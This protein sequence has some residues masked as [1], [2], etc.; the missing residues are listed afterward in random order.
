M[1]K[2]EALR[3]YRLMRCTRDCDLKVKQAAGRYARSHR[4]LALEL[5]RLGFEG[6]AMIQ[7]VDA[8]GTMLVLVTYKDGWAMIVLHPD[9][10]LVHHDWL[11][12]QGTYTYCWDPWRK[13]GK[14]K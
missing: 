3:L 7:E 5:E 12:R 1:T 6:E 9:L 11:P 13:R 4:G 10:G 14:V 8:Q 2:R